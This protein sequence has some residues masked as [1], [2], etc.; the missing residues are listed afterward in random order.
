MNSNTFA[1]E[2][3]HTVFCNRGR[4]GLR[5]VALLLLT[6]SLLFAFAGDA[7]VDDSPAKPRGKPDAKAWK[8]NRD[9]GQKAMAQGKEIQAESFY[10]AALAEA[11]R[12]DSKDVRL[13][14]SLTD[15]GFLRFASQDYAS[16]ETLFGRAVTIRRGE[17]NRLLEA[18]CLLY[19]A[20][21]CRNLEKYDEAEKD[22]LEAQD[23][24]D[25]KAGPDHPDD[26]IIRYH[27]A[28]VYQAKG[29]YSKA[30]PLLVGAVENFVNPPPQ[31]KVRQRLDPALY[32]PA[33]I[34][35][36]YRPNYQYALD[37][38]DSLVSIYVKLN[39]P[40]KAEKCYLKSVKV[41]RDSKASE[42]M[43]QSAELNLGSFYGAQKNYP[44]AQETLERLEHAQEKSPGLSHPLVQQTLA[45]LGRV[46]EGED[47]LPQAE[48]TYKKA[49]AAFEHAAG[50][51]GQ[52]ALN[53]T[54]GL[55]EFYMRHERYADAAS[56]F[57]GLLERA[58]KDRPDDVRDLP[59]WTQLAAVYEKLGRDDG[60]AK[61]YQQ[62]ITT[63]EKTFGRDSKALLKPLDNYAALLSKQNRASEAEA[64]KAR[65]NAIRGVQ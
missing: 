65:A 2:S 11:E 57:E 49:A 29:D 39:Q 51:P 58:Q 41:A 5:A 33:V 27:L 50:A 20:L 37:G 30:E 15:L 32:G 28:R 53:A 47:R 13:A 31:I 21:A 56:T 44:K 61:V 35:Y 12:F 9:E 16:A 4:P 48:A 25:R 22:L 54:G 40:D 43:I 1:R 7:Q 23:I 59:S 24:V 17:L 62:Q 36:T 10:E 26:A 42:L 8:K 55:A 46:Y 3:S 38:L 19:H 64:V 6:G 18:Q 63:Y 14:E 60:L 52:D 34:R 45:K